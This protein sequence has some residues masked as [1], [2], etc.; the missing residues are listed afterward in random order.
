MVGKMLIV[1]YISDNHVFYRTKSCDDKS[2]PDCPPRLSLEEVADATYEPLF[3]VI[4]WFNSEKTFSDSSSDEYK[5]KDDIFEAI[6]KRINSSREAGDWCDESSK[7]GDDWLHAQFHGMETTA[8]RVPSGFQY[9]LKTKPEALLS[10][11]KAKKEVG[12]Q[13]KR[14]LDERDIVK[15]R[16]RL[17][18]Q[19]TGSPE[20][21]GN[22]ACLLA[23]FD[24][25]SAG[26]AEGAE[27]C[28][29]G[30]VD[31]SVAER[32]E[33]INPFTIF[34]K[35]GLDKHVKSDFEN[36]QENLDAESGP[37][38][39]RAA[40]EA[41]HVAEDLIVL[42]KASVRNAI[43]ERR[44]AVFEV[45][46]SADACENFVSSET[47]KALVAKFD[48]S[49]IKRAAYMKANAKVKDFEVANIDKSC[50]ICATIDCVAKVDASLWKGDDPSSRALERLIATP[51]NLK[52]STAFR[53][54]IGGFFKSFVRGRLE[55]FSPRI[56]I[57]EMVKKMPTL[58]K[59]T[60]AGVSLGGSRNFETSVVSLFPFPHVDTL[61]K[62]IIS[63]QVKF[64]SLP[65]LLIFQVGGYKKLKYPQGDNLLQLSTENGEA[66][67]YRLMSQIESIYGVHSS[68]RTSDTPDILIYQKM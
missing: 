38:Q 12:K 19:A 47:S 62:L 66:G 37:A 50:A 18:G 21:T 54:T 10:Y 31:R 9:S 8:H 46:D 35:S 49:E 52:D 61:K 5:C 55:W 23:L 33:L 65:A 56:F 1:P 60:L 44:A 15:G 6:R 59:S 3:S 13:M 53:G 51:G 43:E 68:C 42:K 28:S 34:S 7:W 64:A 63:N 48:D 29:L 20:P 2:T 11:A 25:L 41:Q 40:V 24:G 4:R 57:N 39:I 32:L 36:V 26:P 17:L 14:F 27:E 58:K 22:E 45:A 16:V 67:S 30:F